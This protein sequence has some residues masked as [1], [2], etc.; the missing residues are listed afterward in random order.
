MAP[1]QSLSLTPDLP[2]DLPA[3]DPQVWDTDHPSTAKHHPPVHII[4]KDPLTIITQQQYS[5][6][7]EAHKGLKPIIDHLLQ[8]S[9]LI[10]T[11]SPY[12]TPI[13]AVK[14]GPNS[15]R[16]VQD[17]SKINEAIMPTFPVVP[18]PYTLLRTI[19]PTATHFTVLDLKDA[20]F[21]I[22]LYPLSQPLFAFT[23][24]DPKTHVSQQ[25]ARTVLPQ[26][27]R[28]SPHFFGQALQKDLQ[29][30]NLAPGHLQYVDD[31]LLCSSTQKLCL[32]YTAKLLGALGSWGYRVSQ[33]KA[34]IAQTRVT[35]LGLSI[36]HQQRTIP[37]DRI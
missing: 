32:Q 14:K 36:S 1:G 27:F 26:G 24:Q 30:L 23:W 5:L 9:I 16:L 34:Q 7:P 25:L 20:F 4:L 12:N 33:S 22:P 3:L 31:L 8:A 2:L 13:L 19:P 28:D 37:P 21:T 6:T 29:T 15:W 35:Y 18:N 11:H 10:P 17:L